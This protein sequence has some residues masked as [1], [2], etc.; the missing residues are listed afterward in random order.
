MKFCN[1]CKTEKNIDEFGKSIKT[2][3]GIARYCCNCEKERSKYYN[4]RRKQR[5][6]MFVCVVCEQNITIQT[7]KFKKKKILCCHKCAPTY[8]F[9]GKKRPE[10]SGENNPRWKGDVLYDSK[11][12]KQVRISGE[13]HPCG[14]DKFRK[15]HIVVYE[16]YLGRKLETEF[17]SYSEQIHHIDGDKTNNNI[18]N[19][20]L[21]KGSSEHAKIESQFKKIGCSLVRHG[22]ILFDKETKSYYLHEDFF[23]ILKNNL[24]ILKKKDNNYVLEAKTTT[25]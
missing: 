17:S 11:G 12:Y 18:E 20:I 6:T 1:R 5:L 8:Y 23:K 10:L 13:K 9:Q 2:K 19:L 3:D 7:H 24:S 15:E 14:S 25:D 4:D 22:V 21:C 16:K